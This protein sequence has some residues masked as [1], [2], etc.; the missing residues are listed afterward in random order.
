LVQ[1]LLRTI[2][3]SKWLPAFSRELKEVLINTV[4][5]RKSP[6]ENPAARQCLDQAFISRSSCFCFVTFFCYYPLMKKKKTIKPSNLE[7]EALSQGLAEQCPINNAFF[8]ELESILPLLVFAKPGQKHN[9]RALTM[10][11]TILSL[12]EKTLELTLAQE[13]QAT[14]SQRISQKMSPLQSE[15][16]ET[17]R[18]EN[19][20]NFHNRPLFE[21]LA[22]A[23][24]EDYLEQSRESVYLGFE[25][26]VPVEVQNWVVNWSAKLDETVGDEYLKC[27]T[28]ASL[29]VEDKWQQWQQAVEKIKPQKSTLGIGAK[30]RALKWSGQVNKEK[31]ELGSLKRKLEKDRKRFTHSKDHLTQLAGSLT[32]FLKLQARPNQ[33][34]D[35]SARR[36]IALEV[37]RELHSELQKEIQ[38]KIQEIGKITEIEIRE[39]G[40]IAQK[41]QTL[42]QIEDKKMQI[43]LQ[44]FA[45]KIF[46]ETPDL[47]SATLSHLLKAF[48]PL[49]EALEQVDQMHGQYKNLMKNLRKEFQK[50]REIANEYAE[51]LHGGST[52]PAQD[53]AGLESR[54]ALES[55]GKKAVRPAGLVGTKRN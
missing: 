37:E 38:N 26:I 4:N 20:E 40:K 5:E 12:K 41:K 39:S 1:F 54:D 35:K 48:T 15:N 33:G 23:S 21:N 46:A 3:N 11:E 50:Y 10:A 42:L 55:F 28:D 43:L 31:K 14:Q 34:F 18:A 53:F 24:M 8:E 27:I 47:A 32:A 6:L 29:F 25:S 17:A 22:L 2:L 49:F 9:P 16:K 51:G 7:G 13:T 30:L 45:S 19:S 36:L 44:G 52:T